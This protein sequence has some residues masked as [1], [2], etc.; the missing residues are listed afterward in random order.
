IDQFTRAQG[1]LARERNFRWLRLNSWEKLKTSGWL[2]LDFWDMCK[3]KVP[4]ER[5][6]GRPCYG[7]LDLSSKIDMTAFVLLFPPDDINRKWV[8][9]PWF[10]VPEDAIPERVRVDKVRYDEWVQQGYLKA[11]P[12][13]VI[14]YS[15]IEKE[16][17]DAA[18]LYDIQQIGYDPWNA[19]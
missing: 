8:V 15:F 11:T 19:M 12:G 18:Y 4:L 9:L 17:I 3:G 5:L 6:K 14:D 16:I 1:N 7:G 2:G 10:W 13:N